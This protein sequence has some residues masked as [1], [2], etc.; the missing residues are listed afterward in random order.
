MKCLMNLL[1]VLVLSLGISSAQTPAQTPTQSSAPQTITL[2]PAQIQA[3]LANIPGATTVLSDL[4][5]PPVVKV[6]LPPITQSI[7]SATGVTWLPKFIVTGGGGFTSPNGKFVYG[8][9]SN[10]LGSGTYTTVAVEETLVSGKF[11]SCT[12]AGI[13]KSMY[14]YSYFTVGLTGLGGDCVAT[15]GTA[16][17]AGSGQ[18]FLDVRF[19]KTPFGLTLTGT[20]NTNGGGVKVTLAF[21]WAQ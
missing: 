18:G 1:A 2:T 7:T 17:V 5:A 4:P 19:G 11:E 13:T 8:S 16:A 15:T 12:L 6:P 14:Q 21:R 3:I 9:E 20:K 10:Y